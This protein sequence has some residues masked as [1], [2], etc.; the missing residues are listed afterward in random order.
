MLKLYDVL[1]DNYVIF[2]IE[3]R[4]R[5]PSAR[6]QKSKCYEGKGTEEITPY[7]IPKQ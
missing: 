1:S 3:A 2:F 4:A 6:C 5:V 7:L